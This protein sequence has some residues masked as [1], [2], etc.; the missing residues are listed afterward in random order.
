M[1]LEKPLE[2]ITEL[3]LQSLVDNGTS[4]GKMIEYK[5]S[6]PDDSYDSKK[7]FLADV[8]SFANAAGGYLVFGIVAENGIPVDLAGL[9][10]IDP[11]A[12]ILRLENML[13]D[14]IEPR[15]PG[16]SMRPVPLSQGTVTII[17]R[18]PCSWAQPHVVR[19][20]KHW[21]FYSRNS[22]GKY[23]LDVS[24][25]R[26]AFALSE[27][28]AERIRLFRTERLGK[29]VAGE[30]PVMLEE[31]AKIVLHMVPFGAFHP[32]SARIDLSI[33]GHDVWPVKPINSPRVADCRYNFDG[34][35]TYSQSRT[36]PARSYVQLFRNGAIEAVDASLLRAVRDQPLSI[37]G[38]AYE[39]E[40]VG[41]LQ[42]YLL[43]QG[44]LDVAPPVFVMLSLLGVSGY[45]M[46][47]ARQ[48]DHSR[49]CAYQI[50]LDA[51]VLPEVIVEDFDANPAQVLRPAFDSVWNATGWPRSMNY[52]EAGEWRKGPNWSS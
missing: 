29:I 16:V 27:T 22:A 9:P 6:L 8:S 28:V 17:V 39:S 50:H 44:R 18:V 15:I 46:A 42:E 14:N 2:S 37:P 13:R 7:E 24:E 30:T 12:E 48:L 52:D 49:D 38:K 36:A 3:D 26:A 51:L 21:R 1:P 35:V 45:I 31:N 47:V 4:E 43:I 25:V 20:K 5:A 40:L 32:L 34:L 33:L 19:F 11:D 41:K 23:P 10:S